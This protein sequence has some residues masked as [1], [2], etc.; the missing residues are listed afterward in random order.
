MTEKIKEFIKSPK[1]ANYENIR[2]NQNSEV[3]LE[4]ILKL[5]NGK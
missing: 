5:I 3:F 1:K 2:K 4:E